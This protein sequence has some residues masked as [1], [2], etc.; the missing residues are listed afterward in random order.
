M[1]ST[2]ELAGKLEEAVALGKKRGLDT[3]AWERKLELIKQ[4]QE[5][6]KRTYETLN[7]QG[8]CLWKC[9]AFNEDVIVVVRDELVT[10]YPHGYP[11]YLEQELECLL[12][13]SDLALRLVHEAKKQAGAVV[14]GVEER[15]GSGNQSEK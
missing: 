14:T 6:S 8:W 11:V 2:T 1:S 15:D 4:A 5:V 10:D 9:R 3:S 12:E 13:A 7:T